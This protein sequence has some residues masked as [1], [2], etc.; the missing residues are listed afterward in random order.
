MD[1]IF[2]SADP[3]V[4]VYLGDKRN[5]KKLGSTDIIYNTLNPLFAQ[6]EQFCAEARRIELEEGAQAVLRLRDYDRLTSGKTIGEVVVVSS[7][8][9]ES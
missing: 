3:F 9:R 1:G 4:E 7:D 8:Q 5:E 2:G 6:D